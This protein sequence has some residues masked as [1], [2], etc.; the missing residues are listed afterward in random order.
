MAFK[1]GSVGAPVRWNPNAAGGLTPPLLLNQ[2]WLGYRAGGGSLGPGMF[3]D[4]GA[5]LNNDQAGYGGSATPGWNTASFTEPYLAHG[6]GATA[7]VGAARTGYRNSSTGTPN[8]GVRRDSDPAI[9]FVMATGTPSDPAMG[10]RYWIGLFNQTGTLGNVASGAAPSTEFA[11]FRF[12]SLID[13]TTWRAVT[14]DGVTT[15]AQNTGVTVTTETRYRLT[16]RIKQGVITFQVNGANDI[17]I[18]ANIPAA[19]TLLWLH[20]L[21]IKDATALGQILAPWYTQRVLVRL[22]TPTDFV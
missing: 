18:S 8:G 14:R 6:A 1:R 7:V 15:N 22:G 11:G 3:G 12:D 4:D 10:Y 20:A 13:G 17:N 19:A 5:A 16:I 9:D 2:Y 21:A